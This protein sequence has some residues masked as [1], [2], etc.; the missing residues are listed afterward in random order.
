[1]IT[2]LSLLVYLVGAVVTWAI[3]WRKW[4]EHFGR[5]EDFMGFAVALFEATL[6]ALIWPLAAL[7]YGLYGIYR[8]REA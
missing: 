1:M 8:R 6:S 4:H 5:D 3:V 7:A 2:W